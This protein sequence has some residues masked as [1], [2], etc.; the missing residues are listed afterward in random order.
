MDL[1]LKGKVAIVTG[2]GQ[3]CGKAYCLA[4]AEEGAKVVVA[5]L[6]EDTA[7]QTAKEIAS[8][9]IWV[10]VVP[11][12]YDAPA[13]LPI[14]VIVIAPGEPWPD[15]AVTIVRRLDVLRRPVGRLESQVVKNDGRAAHVADREGDVALLTK[16]SVAVRSRY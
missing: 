6:N 14:H 8:K 15:W 1:G 5:D 16:V 4:F 10:A 11:F 12:G 9:R 3:G 2:G 13:G 7:K